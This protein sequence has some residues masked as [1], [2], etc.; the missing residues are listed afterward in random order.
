MISFLSHHLFKHS[1]R[2]R[3]LAIGILVIAFSAATNAQ[4][5]S[6]FF[7]HGQGVAPWTMSLQFGQIKIANKQA[8]TTKSSLVASKTVDDNDAINLVWRSRGVKNQWGSEDKSVSTLNVINGQYVSDFGNNVENSALLLNIRI[9][10]APNKNVEL[11]MECN[12]DWQCRSSIPLKNMLKRLPKEKWLNVPV[13]VKCFDHSAFDLTKITSPFMLY[14]GGRMDIDIRS[15][16]IIT[17]PEGNF[18]C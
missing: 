17:L 7:N 10:K 14:T 8:K 4:V 5:R 3:Q 18:A 16:S 12:W 13:P 2:S 9:N 6:V 11:T 15:I 1:T